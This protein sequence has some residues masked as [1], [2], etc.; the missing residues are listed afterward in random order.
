M[1][2]PW[3]AA[4]T[5]NRGLSRCIAPLRVYE[6][7]EKLLRSSMYRSVARM[8]RRGEIWLSGQVQRSDPAS[9]GRRYIGRPQRVGS[10]LL[11]LFGR[12]ANFDG[13]R[14]SRVED[15][16]EVATRDG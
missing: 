12:H 2:K 7:R 5:S 3:S 10:R 14:Y 9:I 15:I 8:Q 4:G 1:A 16:H 13:I 11:T 6:F